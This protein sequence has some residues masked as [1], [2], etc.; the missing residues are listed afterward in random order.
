MWGGEPGGTAVPGC[1]H[2]QGDSFP[3]L[4]SLPLKLQ[5]P[6]SL[7]L[8]GVALKQEALQV[9]KSESAMHTAG[10]QYMLNIGAFQPLLG[11]LTT[12]TSGPAPSDSPVLVSPTEFTE[13]GVF[14]HSAHTQ[15]WGPPPHCSTWQRAVLLRHYIDTPTPCFQCFKMR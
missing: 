1:M 15:T 7:L 5:G 10:A 12:L 14:E 8:V 3:P 2:P 9:N 6:P 4:S 11:P 13:S